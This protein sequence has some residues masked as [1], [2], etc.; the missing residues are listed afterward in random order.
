[1]KCYRR[2]I[3][4]CGQSALALLACS[5]YV[6]PGV[7]HAAESAPV[8]LIQAWLAFPEPS[9]VAWPY[10]Y[11]RADDT[12][13]GESGARQDLLDEY[14]RL[15][16][17]LEDG[18]YTKL[19]DSVKAWKAK[20]TAIDAFRTPGD[21]SPAYLMAHVNKNPPI[22]RVV[23]LGACQVPD[24]VTV[25]D[26]DGVRDIVWQSSMRLSDIEKIAPATRDGS[27]PEIT[28]VGP[29]GDIDHYGV[30]AWNYADGPVAPGSQIVA[31]LP[32]KGAAFVWIRDAMAT[33]L[34]HVPSGTDCREVKL[35][36]AAQ[37]D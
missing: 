21:W 3:Q 10:A 32:L 1:M 37:D 6:G 33:L 31:S 8:T 4:A 23:A 30:Q 11:I 34:A 19:A 17:R 5:L 27:A 12:H 26:A 22:A 28:V 24:T 25:W 15:L 7:V 2:F 13:V 29:Y 20:L 9:D 16:W 35:A 36:G 14:D 18:G